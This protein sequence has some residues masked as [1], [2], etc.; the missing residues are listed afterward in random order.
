MPL[1]LI[2]RKSNETGYTK[3][4]NLHDRDKAMAIKDLLSKRCVL[5]FPP[6]RFEEPAWLNEMNLNFRATYMNLPNIDNQ[7]GRR[8]INYSSLHN[9]QKWIFDVIYD[10]GFEHKI[11]IL[12]VPTRNGSSVD[13][14][15]HLG[16]SGKS[17]SSELED[18]IAGFFRSVKDQGV[19]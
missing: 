3:S 12:T 7:T 15:V 14:P 13:V 9:N 10:R 8:L 6:N 18:G 11:K 5:Y 2:R 19:C 17:T 1:T 16:Y 4:V